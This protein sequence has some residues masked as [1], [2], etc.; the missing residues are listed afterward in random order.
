MRALGLA[1][2]GLALFAFARVGDVIE[3]DA[4]TH[5]LGD[6]RTP[7]WVEAPPDPEGRVLELEFRASARS[8]E[9]VL[10]LTQRH[11]DNVW[12]IEIN[13]VRVAR[14][15]R[16]AERVERRYIVPGGVLRDGTNRLRVHGESPSD[17]I[18][19]GAL[20]LHT[21]TLRELLD[22]VP[23]V[24]RV[25]DAADGSA[26]P[27]RV[28][29]FD[30]AGARVPIHYGERELSAVREGLCY[31]ADGEARF[32][33]PR[34]RWRVAATR[35][36]EWSL[37]EAELSTEDGP[38]AVALELRREV[39]TRGFI[40]C[41][42]HVHTFTHSGHGD[43]TVEE[44]QVTLAGEGVEL[45]IATD[46][47]HQTDYRPAQAALGLSRWYTPVVG[48]EVTTDI[49]HFNA[50]PFDPE[51]PP[52]A[53]DSKDV[54]VVVAGIRAA[55]AEVVILNHPRWPDHQRG[56][57]GVAELDLGT[58]AT[59]AWSHPYDALELIN[60]ETDEADPVSLF[61]DWFALLDRGE[62]LV[63]VA[64]SDSHTVDGLVGGGRTYLPSA[65]D[66]PAALDVPALARAMRE[67][68][69]SLSMGI[70][71][72]VRVEGHRAGELVPR[73][74]SNTVQVDVRSASWVRPRLLSVW[75]DGARVASIELAPVEGE[76]FDAR[77]ELEVPARAHDAWLVCLVEG[78]GVQH[79]AWPLL[80]PYTLAAT[81]PVFLDGDGDGRYSAPRETARRLLEQRGRGEDV[82]RELVEEVDE[83][84]ALQALE[85][86]RAAWAQEADRALERAAGAPGEGRERLRAW[87]EARRDR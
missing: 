71:A 9:S 87:L 85:L 72:D 6:S 51:A 50:F 3:I 42:T 38:A 36:M 12:W 8:E 33:V 48:N 54:E 53:W 81:N 79:P 64:S 21:R 35:G 13:D 70:F 44:R 49:G 58:G 4:T 65:T 57:F 29:V 23:V 11:V 22:L 14:L 41:D 32:E 34:G 25:R 78:D 55:G 31:Q 24:V 68:R 76:P 60:S 62:H 1:F 66:D 52:P 27:A 30:D 16:T 83:A 84:V 20:R 73:A 86:A 40:A 10:E 2:A 75:V 28:T 67:G 47:N 26:M 82:L 45:A 69:S 61:R 80:N 77:I 63:A 74:A 59:R 46:H 56:P 7:D 5:H 37:A 18:T 17:D 19:I 39:D 43:A 15:A